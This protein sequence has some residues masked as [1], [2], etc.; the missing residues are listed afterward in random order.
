[1]AGLQEGADLLAAGILEHEHGSIVDGDGV[2]DV[3]QE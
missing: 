3:R 2:M 1:M